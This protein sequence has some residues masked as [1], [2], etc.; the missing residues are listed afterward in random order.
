MKAVTL[1]E[2]GDVDQLHLEDVEDPKRAC[3][4]DVLIRVHASGL[5][6]ADLL[7]RRGF[8]PPPKGASPILGLEV[9]GTIEELGPDAEAAGFRKGESV[10]ALLAGGGYAEKVLTRHDQLMRVPKRIDLLAAGGL[11]E[12]FVT[13]YLELLELGRLQKGERVLIHA[14][15]S[16]V[17]SAAIQIAKSVGAEIWVTA[18]SDEK[19]EFCRELGAKHLINYRKESFADR[20]QSGTAG[21][22][23][24]C[25]LDLVGAS[26]FAGNMASLAFDGRLLFVGLGGG[27]KTEIDLRQV[28]AKRASLIGST[29]RSRSLDDKARLIKNF[30]NFARVPFESGLFRPLI[31]KV[32]PANDVRDA[33]RYMES[34]QNQGKIVLKW[35]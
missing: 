18:G 24:H 1:N 30:W 33:H 31:D 16:G 25:I 6:G 35:S 28:L 15:A 8:Y 21:E 7:Q 17:G 5:N 20:I 34:Q 12:V 10:M 3:E 29:L 14:G 19:L 27:A 9:S 11:V 23:V 2:F 13:A 22:G 26:H 32:F 4:T